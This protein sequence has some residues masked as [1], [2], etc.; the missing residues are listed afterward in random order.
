MRLRCGLSLVLFDQD[1]GG[2]RRPKCGDDHRLGRRPLGARHYGLFGVE[3]VVFRHHDH[4]DPGSS[5]S[6][7][8]KVIDDGGCLQG[9]GARPR[10]GEGLSRRGDGSLL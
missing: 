3:H 10:R 5:C 1:H 6:T 2:R 8:V 9:A 7:A 4:G